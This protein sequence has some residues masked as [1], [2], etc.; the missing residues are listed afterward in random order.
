MVALSLT[1]S[2]LLA[3]LDGVAPTSVVVLL[4]QRV[5][6]GARQSAGG[7]Q[8]RGSS[9]ELCGTLWKCSVLWQ[10]KGHTVLAARPPLLLPPAAARCRSSREAD[11]QGL[12][13]RVFNGG[14]VQVHPPLPALQRL[15]CGAARGSAVQ[16]CSSEVMK[17]SQQEQ[18]G[19]RSC[20][21]APPIWTWTCTA[22][23]QAEEARQQ[24]AAHDGGPTWEWHATI[25]DQL[26]LFD[27]R[28]PAAARGTAG[29][30]AR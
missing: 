24:H 21:F 13:A 22:A 12:H 10:L 3:H 5:P 26:P 15:D 2:V 4:H 17:W 29:T 20:R 25:Q 6:A 27:T 9:A 19:R 11:G 8:V 16:P 23:P 18:E 1:G 14:P 30:A 28:H 7:Q